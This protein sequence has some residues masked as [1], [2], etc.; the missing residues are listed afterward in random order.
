MYVSHISYHLSVGSEADKDVDL[1]FIDGLAVYC[2]LD[3]IHVGKF[4]YFKYVCTYKVYTKLVLTGLLI[5][6][7]S[8]LAL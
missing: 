3:N 4:G 6:T 8:S 5:Y 1:S 7:L 2:D